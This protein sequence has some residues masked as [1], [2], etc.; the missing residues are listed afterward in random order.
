MKYFT[1]HV[2]RESGD[3]YPGKVIE[4]PN[5]HEAM[6]QALV[7]LRCAEGMTEIKHDNTRGWYRYVLGMQYCPNPLFSMTI[8]GQTID[9]WL[10]TTEDT[11]VYIMKLED[12]HRL[13]HFLDI[14][15]VGTDLSQY[16]D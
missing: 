15:P 3:T 9:G 16:E 8:L 14:V 5:E 1:W 7:Q 13:Y 2:D 4:A 11:L 12:I 6:Y 10:F